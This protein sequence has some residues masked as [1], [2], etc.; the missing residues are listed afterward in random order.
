MTNRMHYRK[1]P[2]D[3]FNEKVGR[4]MCWEL[5]FAVVVCSAL[6]M[7]CL[8]IAGFLAPDPRAHTEKDCTSCIKRV[9]VCP[10]S[11]MQQETLCQCQ[12]CSYLRGEIARE[13][14]QEDAKYLNCDKW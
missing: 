14:L 3:E 11:Q 5:L 13:D 10:Q 2:E 4:V 12:T 8:W 6:F 9:G 1:D 7:G